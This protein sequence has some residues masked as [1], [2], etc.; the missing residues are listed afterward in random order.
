MNHWI[1]IVTTQVSDGHKFAAEEVLRQRIEDAFWGLGEGTPNR[2]NLKAGDKVVFYVGYPIKSFAA[3]ATLATDAFRLSE[4]QQDAVSHGT[5]FYRPPW[6]V[7]LTDLRV[8]DEKKSAPNLVPVLDFIENKTFWGTYLQGGIRG[9]KEDDFERI[10][11][12]PVPAPLAPAFQGTDS[13]S[14]FALEAHLEEFIDRNWDNIDFGVPL[15]KYEI[16]GQSGRQFPVG[17]WSIDFLCTDEQS[18]DFVVLELKRGQTSDS[19]IGQLLRYVA[20]VKENIA[21]P[22]QSV[23]GLIVAKE[24]DDALRYAIKAVPSIK[25]LTYR[26]DFK[27]HPTD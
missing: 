17:S 27:L 16:E 24:I 21:K 23:K 18:G 14:E 15:K 7:R 11:G 5:E 8:W 10:V 20:Y 26:V 22:G 1:F 19:T 13:A 4:E 25:I 3:N 12:A 6:G 2:K 9:I